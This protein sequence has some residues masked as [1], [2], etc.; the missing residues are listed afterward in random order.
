MRPF[1]CKHDKNRTGTNKSHAYKQLTNNNLYFQ[2]G[3]VGKNIFLC[4]NKFMN[5]FGLFKANFQP[6]KSQLYNYQFPQKF[7]WSQLV[8][9]L[10]LLPVLRQKKERVANPCDDELNCGVKGAA[11]RRHSLWSNQRWD[12]QC[13]AERSLHVGRFYNDLQI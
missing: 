3:S 13:P 2:T 10:M 12:L 4:R 6:R 7:L 11:D 5:D 9:S 1:Y 8:S